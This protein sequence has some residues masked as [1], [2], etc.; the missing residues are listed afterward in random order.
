MEKT[1]SRLFSPSH[2]NKRVPEI[3]F[4]IVSPSYP[5]EKKADLKRPTTC[6]TAVDTKKM[7]LHYKAYAGW[8]SGS[9]ET[10]RSLT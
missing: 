1:F 2:K 7:V 9:T 6:R 8:L 3:N 10:P 4:S 5:D